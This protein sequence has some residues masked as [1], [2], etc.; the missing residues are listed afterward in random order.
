MSI[1]RFKTLYDTQA[2]AGTGDWVPLDVRYDD[3]SEVRTLII[4]VTSGDTVELQGIV[5]D[6]KGMDKSFL[7]TLQTSDI[8]TLATYTESDN[9]V[10]EG[11]WTYIRVV[12]SGTSGPC[13]VS[14]FV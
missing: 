5:K 2:A 13:K 10:L 7:D 4:S 11:P 14:G 8:T 3:G 1:K 12:K 9:D 6:V